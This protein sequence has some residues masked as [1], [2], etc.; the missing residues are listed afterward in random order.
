LLFRCENVAIAGRIVAR[1]VAL[2]QARLTRPGET[3]RN[4]PG[5]PSNSRSGEELLFWAGHYLTQARDA[6]LSENARE[7]WYPAAFLDQARNLTFR[8]GTS[9]LGE[10]WP[11]L[12]AQARRARLSECAKNLPG[13]LL[14]SR[15]SE[16]LQL[17]RGDSSRL[18]EGFWLERDLLQATLFLHLVDMD[19]LVDWFTLFK[20]W[21]LWNAWNICCYELDWCVI[22]ILVCKTNEMVGN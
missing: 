16:S 22:V 1:S 17:E 4:K 5:L 20:V 14:R 11:C 21:V 18:S 8:R 10:G 15:L 2:T 3:C 13:P 9:P 7:P 19:C 12:G 6:R